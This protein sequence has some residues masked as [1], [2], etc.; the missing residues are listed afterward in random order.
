M[1]VIGNPTYEKATEIA[2][3]NLLP[4]AGLLYGFDYFQAIDAL[5]LR[6]YPDLLNFINDLRAD[7]RGKLL[8]ALNV[9]YVVA[10]HDLDVKGLNLVREFPEH[11]S[12]LYE[13]RASVPRAYLVGRSTYE[14]DP[15]NTLR[16]L[17]S[18][19]FDPRREVVLD[20]P[21]HLAHEGAIDGD[22]KITLYGNQNVQIDAQLGQPGVRVLAAAF[23]PG[24]KAFVDGKEQRV[25]RA[26]YLFRAVE[27]GAGNHRVEF[28]YDPLSFKIGWI[29]SLLTA[30]ALISISLASL[31]QRRKRCRQAADTVSAE[32]AHAVLD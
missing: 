23:Y 29:I 5:G 3:N 20:A 12:R 28:I 22:A 2:F 19:E 17:V 24:W 1:R 11:Y 16:R 6:S 10:F 14:V 4:N 7:R 21:T 18:D 25:L 8:G 32:P 13:V 9:K 26:N 31:V 15:M 27:L 30:A